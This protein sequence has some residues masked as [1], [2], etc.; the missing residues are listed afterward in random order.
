MRLNV[1]SQLGELSDK[2]GLLYS[3][4]DGDL[5]PLMQG[6]GAIVESS[7]RD[8]FRTKTAP[9]GSSWAD[10]KPATLEAKNGRGGILV[11]QGDL[12]R[13]ITAH[14]TGVSVVVGSDR[15]SAKYHQTGTKNSDGSERMVARPIFGLSADDYTDIRDLVNDFME[16]L[17]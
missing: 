7:T 8:H 11:D 5:T 13:S 14:A 6:I 17:I 3:R 1:E 10:L 15:P 2:I 9:D 4:L 16:D 12:M